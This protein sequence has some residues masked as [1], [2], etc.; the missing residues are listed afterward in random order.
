MREK[1][2]DFEVR[3][4]VLKELQD[5]LNYPENAKFCRTMAFG[6]IFFATNHLFS[7]YNKELADWWENDILPMFNTIIRRGY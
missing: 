7:T 2:I 4:Y 5:A 6:A 1:D 3:D